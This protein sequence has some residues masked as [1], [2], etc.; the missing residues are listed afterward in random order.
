MPFPE[1]ITRLPQ[2]DIP[3]PGVTAYLAQAGEQQFVFMSFET[4]AEIPEHFHEAQW[5]V[6]LEGEMELTIE[7]R[8]QLLRKGDSYFVPRNA[9]HHASFR[10]GYKDL[11]LF[12]QKDRYALVPKAQKEVS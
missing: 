8:T 4:Y 1:I 2:A 6:V 9:K 5:G 3:I 10:M 12:D 7:G 11:T